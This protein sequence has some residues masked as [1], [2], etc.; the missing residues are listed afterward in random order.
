MSRSRNLLS[1][2]AAMLLVAP[3]LHAVDVTTSGDTKLRVYGFVHVYANYFADGDQQTLGGS[4]RLASSMFYAGYGAGFSDFSGV[5]TKTFRMDYA[6]TRLGFATTTPTAGVG[7]VTTKIEYDHNGTNYGHIRLA[8]AGIGDW[9]FGQQWSL[10]VDGDAGADTV[11]WA[12]PIG[13]ACYDTP[14]FV[15]INWNHKIDKNNSIAFA[16]EENTGFNDGKVGGS[17]TAKG[18][19]PTFI[20]AYTYGADWGHVKAAVLAQNYAVSNAA[21]SAAAGTYYVDPKT[22]HLTVTDPT[23]ASPSVEFS[24]MASAFNIAKDTLIAGVYSGSGLGQYGTGIQDYQID[25]ANKDFVFIK[26][27]GWVVGYTHTWTD[28]VR[29]NI[30]LSGVTFSSDDKIAGTQ[31][32]GSTSSSAGTDT[33]TGLPLAPTTTANGQ[34]VK[35]MTYGTINTFVKVAKNAEVGVEYV[36]ES[37]KA[38]SSSDVWTDKDGNATNKQTGSKIEVSLHVG[39]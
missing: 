24:K 2:L 7:D 4:N 34:L 8:Q 3:T 1:A 33:T 25:T 5:P 22:G 19:M 29:S 31:S 12:G 38:F 39:F 18:K 11:D 27:T 15:A 32:S 37:A 26:S 28:A 10:W 35:T 6:P 23:T 13:S 36:Y 14:R 30:V 9:T 17:G 16:A 21:T 20:G